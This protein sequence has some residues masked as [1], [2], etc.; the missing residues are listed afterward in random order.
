M[1]R[2]LIFHKDADNYKKIFH[3][4]N[5]SLDIISTSDENI[6]RNTLPSSEIVVAMNFPVDALTTASHLRWLQIIS[7]GVEFLVPVK[8][9]IKH[10]KVTNGRGIHSQPIAD[11]VM[12]AMTML[13]FDF[14]SFMQQQNTRTWIRRSIVPLASRTVGIIGLGMIGQEIAKRAYYSD[15]NVIGLTR[16]STSIDF[17]KNIYHVNQIDFFLKELDFLVIATPATP[18]N[19]NLIDAHELACLKPSAFL[20]NIARGSLVNEPALIAALRDKKIAGACL[21]VFAYEP[22]PIESLLWD[23]SNVIITPHIAGMRV[24]YPEKFTDLFFEN[25]RRYDSGEDLINTVDFQ[26]GY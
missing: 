16:S 25:L 2:I 20:I 11:Y 8:A 5:N 9:Q 21:D 10:L 7:S 6:F 1:A 22:L 23:L 18:E 15:M 17:V 24:D 19:Y 3:E 13:A 14:P 4:R 26:R 12:S